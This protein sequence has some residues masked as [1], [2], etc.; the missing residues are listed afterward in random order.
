MKPK[1]TPE[2]LEGMKFADYRKL[3]Y[4]ELK[5]MKAAGTDM[6][7]M[8]MTEYEFSDFPGKKLPFLVIGKLASPWKKYYKTTAKKRNPKDFSLGKCSFGEAVSG[9]LF[10][11]KLEVNNGKINSRGEK[12]LEKAL[13]KKVKLKPVVVENLQEEEDTDTEENTTKEKVA[14]TVASTAGK[15]KKTP[16]PEEIAALKEQTKALKDSIDALKKN[17]EKVKEKVTKNLKKNKSGRKDLLA[18]RALQDSYKAFVES[19][20]QADK[21]LKAKFAGAKK[22]LDEQNASFAKLALAVK[23]RKKSL[24]QKL[25]DAFF[26]KKADRLANEDEIKMMQDSIKA[27][28]EYRKV[29]DL[30]GSEKKLNL[31]AV[32]AT[33]KYKGPKFKAKHT[34]LVYNH[35]K[36]S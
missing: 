17:F 29:K 32:F 13:L 5:R 18:M 22:K 12:A 36:A 2:S 27:A 25:A 35:L 21:K 15:K 11:F 9:G 3:L 16:S 10:E 14:A 6:E 24:A 7:F 26:Q 31:K 28:L 20:D 33:A 34:D 1:I 19:Y 30:E 4:K 23:L 8:M